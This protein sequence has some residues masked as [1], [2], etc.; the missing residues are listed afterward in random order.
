MDKQT[1]RKLQTRRQFSEQIRRQAVA[2]FQPVKRLF[3]QFVDKRL[4]RQ[5]LQKISR[6]APLDVRVGDLL[7]SP[8]SYLDHRERSF[9][10]EIISELTQIQFSLTEI[11]RTPGQTVTFD[12]PTPDFLKA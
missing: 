3:V 7:N 11:C 4:V 8:D 1:K 10:P 12:L 9:E 6:F 2:E 5:K